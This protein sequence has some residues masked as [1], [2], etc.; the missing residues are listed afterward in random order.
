MPL[1][2]HTQSFQEEREVHRAEKKVWQWIM[3]QAR[4]PEATRKQ[5]KGGT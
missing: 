4:T 3:G 1:Q 2:M 5:K